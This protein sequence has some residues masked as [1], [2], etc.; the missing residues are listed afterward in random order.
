MHFYYYY[1]DF[2]NHLNFYTE[3]FFIVF[4]MN[5]QF[6]HYL[7]IINFQN[8]ISLNLKFLSNHFQFFKLIFIQILTIKLIKKIK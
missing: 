2:R 7:L 1:F 6:L 5:L 8:S 3:Y 4:I